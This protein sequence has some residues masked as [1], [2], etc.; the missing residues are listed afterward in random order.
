MSLKYVV[1]CDLLEL[2]CQGFGVPDKSLTSSLVMRE[3]NTC[4][5]ALQGIVCPVA[6]LIGHWTLCG[7]SQGLSRFSTLYIRLLTAMVCG[8]REQQQSVE[9]S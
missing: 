7:E 9:V 4:H 3:E 2:V 8:W 5:S 6:Q 1:P